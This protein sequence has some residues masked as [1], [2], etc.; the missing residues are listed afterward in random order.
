MNIIDRESTTPATEKQ[1][2]EWLGQDPK[3]LPGIR[4]PPDFEELAPPQEEIV[5]VVLVSSN[6]TSYLSGR[7]GY[8]KSRVA[9]FL[10]HAFRS[11]GQRVAVT[12]TITTAA[13]SI[14]GVRYTFFCSWPRDSSPG[15]TH[16]TRYGPRSKK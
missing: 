2:A 5:V 9:R 13:G 16:P 11:M 10:V 4:A 1:V 12:G 6:A 15:L 8:G 14:G 7:A 3:V